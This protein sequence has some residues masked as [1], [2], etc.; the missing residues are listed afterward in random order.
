MIN[1]D[2][3]KSQLDEK[4]VAV[5]PNP[6]PKA[7]LQKMKSTFVQQLTHPQFNTWTGYQQNEKWRLLIEDLLTLSPAF[8]FPVLNDS[9]MEVCRQYIGNNFQMTEARGW[10]T[11]RTNRNFHGWHNDAWYDVQACGTPPAQLKMGIYLS[12]V[13]SG[14]FCYVET[15]HKQKLTPDHWN[16][17]Q[18][19]NMNLP[20]RHVKGKA[21]TIF[22][23]DTCGIHRQ[24]SPILN[25]RNVIFF[26]FHD[27][28]IPIQALDQS[29][30]RYAPLLLNAA[31][32]KNLT[33]EQER[34][35]GFGDTRY[36]Q[37]AAIPK[38]RYP[39][40]HKLAK[41]GLGLRLLLQ[42]FNTLYQRFMRFL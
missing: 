10:Q 9:L 21:G 19:K 13:D 37:E 40:L 22:L 11:I 1:I 18:V 24:N 36:F 4:G 8:L 42:D 29:Y 23:F 33:K 6:L 41:L 30:N 17:K 20:V 38:Q 16:D 2:Y 39:W 14:E 31:F 34:I 7:E 12:D 25:K 3:V 35:L 5:L 15:T 27:P 26:N 32:L 28:A